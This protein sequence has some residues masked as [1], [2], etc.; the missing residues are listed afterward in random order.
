MI[1]K[2]LIILSVVYSLAFFNLSAGRIDQRLANF[3]GSE[4]LSSAKAENQTITT[5]T[6]RNLPE[7]RSGAPKA[8]INVRQYLLAD[9][10]TGEV[11]LSKDSDQRIPIASITKIMTA[12]IV[13]E[14]YNLSDV[15][16]VPA[17]ATQQTPT[18]VNLR[19][20]EQIT[21]SELLNCLLIKSGNDA[22]YAIAVFMD[23]SGNND[24]APF[25]EKM[26]QK[27]GELR[28]DNTHFEDPAG[29]NDAGYST[30]YDLEI[31]TRYALKNPTFR[32]II[33]MPEYV[34]KNT[35]GTIFHRLE[36][37]NRLITTYQY[38]GAIGVKTGFTY[39]A[40]HSL[41]GA[42]ER[43]GHTLIAV[44]LS[45][46]VDSATA[47]ADEAKKLLDWGFENIVWPK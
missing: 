33:K 15:V 21:V 17:A 32:Q 38:L 13:L 43:D 41:V 6:L 39:A 4:E 27:V 26:N 14:N 11:L 40:S 44:I 1:V 46:Y 8:Y 3:Y 22:A 12:I 10:D 16:T 18:L 30:A 34:A 42:A 9:L 7:I 47:S 28:L 37:S 23:K 36:N 31:I 5:P 24:I 20:G 45:T 25:V 29:L 2:P 35:T 19:A